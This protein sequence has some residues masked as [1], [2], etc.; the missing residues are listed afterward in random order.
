MSTLLY[1]MEEARAPGWAGGFVA[2]IPVGADLSA[3]PDRLMHALL[4]DPDSPFREG[5]SAHCDRAAA[6]YERRLKGD[7]PGADEW[8]AIAEGHPEPSR[9]A[10]VAANFRLNPDGP[11]DTATAL[12]RATRADPS[13]WVFKGLSREEWNGVGRRVV[14]GTAILQRKPPSSIP[15]AQSTQASRCARCR[16]PGKPGSFGFIDIDDPNTLQCVW[17][18]R[19]VRFAFGIFGAPAM[20]AAA[21]GRRAA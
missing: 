21:A 4:S 10:A 20:V 13:A 19:G 17:A 6:L 3:L 18:S 12:E 2:A 16:R 9:L 5:N 11:W 1:N 14:Q 8:R 15:D 7:E